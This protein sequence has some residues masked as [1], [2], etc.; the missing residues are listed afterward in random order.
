[1]RKTDCER[2][3]ETLAAVSSGAWPHSCD[4]AL[5]AHV[6]SCATCSD[7]TDV[8]SALLDDRD[9]ALRHAP[10]PPSGLVWWRMQMRA[11]R[12]GMHA[13]RRTVILVQAAVFVAV[14]GI[15]AAVFAVLGK[16]WWDKLV[17]VNELA[18]SGLAVVTQWGVPL[19]LALAVWLALAPVAF[20]L[21]VTED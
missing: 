20:W 13:A 4:A 7:L 11:R 2:E 8:A 16:G 6:H 12:D 17:P 19:L 9:A 14:L 1:V 21:A 15:A 10:L 3:I 18:A 5:R